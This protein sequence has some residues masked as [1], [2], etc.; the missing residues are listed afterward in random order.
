MRQRVGGKGE[1]L[2]DVYYEAYKQGIDSRELPS[3]IE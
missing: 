1:T 3:I 2:A